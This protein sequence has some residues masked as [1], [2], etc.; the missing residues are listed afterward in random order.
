MTS[1]TLVCLGAG[2]LSLVASIGMSIVASFDKF[3]KSNGKAEQ[4]TI[5]VGELSIPTSLLITGI[6]IISQNKSLI[7]LHL[8]SPIIFAGATIYKKNILNDVVSSNRS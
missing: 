1:T 5:P 3:Y 6:T 2:S 7:G 4:I 8:I